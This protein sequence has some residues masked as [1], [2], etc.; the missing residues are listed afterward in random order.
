MKQMFRILT[1]FIFSLIL[2]TSYFTSLASAESPT[3][4]YVAL[5]DSLAAGFLNSSEIGD[6]YPEYIKQKI[7]EETLYH[8]DLVNYGVGGYT[9][10][11]LL[12]Q[13]KRE[14]VKQHL[15]EA[16]VITID[17]GANDI[18][19]KIGNKFDLTDPDQMQ[20]IIQKVSDAVVAIESNVGQIFTN[21]KELNDEAPI[22]FMG[23]YNALPY[24]NGQE[25]IEFMMTIFN[26]TLQETSEKYGAI[27]VPTYEAF[28]GKHDIYLP[29]PN[30]IHPTKEGYEL[31]ASLFVE[32]ML[33]LLPPIHSVPEITLHGDNPMKLNKGE[34]YVEP[35]AAA[36]D[37]LDGD[38][39][40]L[41]EVIGEV[42]TNKVGEYTL[43][44]S[45]TNSLGVTST[46]QRIIYVVENDHV[47]KQPTS[48]KQNKSIDTS[49]KD[50]K[51]D[52]QKLSNGKKVEKQKETSKITESKKL[53]KTATS[54]PTII[55]IG[56]LCLIIGSYFT[57]FRQIS[58]K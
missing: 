48:K 43:T 25:M 6:G 49:I 4:N 18:L 53:P 8:V 45:V 23:Y 51:I 13:L 31:I 30:D 47:P 41:I 2:I 1:S 9:T 35:G 52:I 39:T 42:N 14:D 22:F 26:N 46:V 28:A 55:L 33:P 17:I 36:Y 19:R 32:E 58:I 5:G 38:L 16:D 11:D 40:D 10:V 54:H 20:E 56:A 50:D 34:T 29:N 7:E 57:F 27:F 3:L 44:Y 12:E 37:S 21:I 24:L 15:K